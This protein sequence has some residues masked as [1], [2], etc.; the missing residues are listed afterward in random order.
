MLHRFPVLESTNTTAK[1]LAATQPLPLAVLA[2]RQCGGRGRLGRSF[3]SAPGGLYFSY[4]FRPP[5]ELAFVPGLT[6]LGAL[7]MADA[8]EQ[9]GCPR[10]AIKWPN[11][12]LLQDKK[13]CGILTEAVSCKE[14]L[15]V[16]GFGVNLTNELPPEL[17]HAANLQSLLGHAPA[18][19]L[20]A[21]TLIDCLEQV[22]REPRDYAMS[23]YR[24]DC[25]TLGQSV[26]V[27]GTDGTVFSGTAVDVQPDG[28]LSVKTAAGIVP[29][30][31]GEASISGSPIP[32]AYN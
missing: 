18:P 23:R 24:A 14:L 15:I 22:F 21:E 25:I 12:L 3:A 32:S 20:L 16:M 5:C 1:Q 26:T 7:A 2:E 11:D 31:S 17:P 19:E 10:P 29:I 6:L 9:L 27:T 28:A 30:R 4:A 8:L 13:I